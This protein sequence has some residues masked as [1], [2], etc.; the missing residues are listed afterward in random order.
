[1]MA[2][3]SDANR[4]PTPHRHPFERCLA[5]AT[6]IVMLC[7]G[8]VDDP[9]ESEPVGEV[10]DGAPSADDGPMHADAEADM[11]P[12]RCGPRRWQ[13]V[14]V[15]IPRDGSGTREVIVTTA[16]PGRF[17]LGE[18]EGA[19]E[20]RFPTTPDALALPA[21]GEAVVLTV[22]ACTQE[23]TDHYA[24]LTRLDGMLLWEGG[25]PGCDRLEGQRLRLLEDTTAPSCHFV[26]PGSMAAGSLYTPMQVE[27]AA[28]DTVRVRHEEQQRVE[29]DGAAFGVYVPLAVD[30]EELAPC[31]DCPDA[32]G[33]AWMGR[34]AD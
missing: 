33:S 28:D 19:V 24:R 1:M 11:L 9:V 3:P 13:W 26:P 6:T 32:V 7:A 2:H 29:V 15:Q 31:D 20:I 25:A 16:E 10:P 18:G 17:V 27:V 22:A 14:E 23:P 34:L 8:C 30:V 12:P 4:A 5:L 21:V